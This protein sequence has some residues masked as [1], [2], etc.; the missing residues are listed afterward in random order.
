M[1][2]IDGTSWACCAI[3]TVSILTNGGGH[4][5][6]NVLVAREK[7]LSYDLLIGIDTVRAL[8]GIT[9]TPAR[10]VKLGGEKEACA[11]LCVNEH[12]ILM[13]LS[14]ITRGYGPPGENGA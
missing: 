9:I 14:T 4:A 13:P 12:W 6:V 2:A 5:I 11:A 8:G 3:G 7:L 10:D 1:W